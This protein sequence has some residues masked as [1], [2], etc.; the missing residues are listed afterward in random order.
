MSARRAISRLVSYLEGAILVFVVELVCGR[1]FWWSLV[2]ILPFHPP[3]HCHKYMLGYENFM[4]SSVHTKV[5]DQQKLLENW[6]G[7]K[8]VCAR[9]SGLCLVIAIVVQYRCGSSPSGHSWNLSVWSTVVIKRWRM[10]MERK[11]GSYQPK[12]NPTILPSPLR[13]FYDW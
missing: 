7:H 6:W 11:R 1:N 13:S 10:K 12:K 4:N 3:Q 8:V 5:A 9:T 2:A